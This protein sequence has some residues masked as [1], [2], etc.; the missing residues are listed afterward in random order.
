[1]K[2]PPPILLPPEDFYDTTESELRR[3][4]KFTR[5]LLKQH[6][7]VKPEKMIE[8]QKRESVNE[9]DDVLDEFKTKCTL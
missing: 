3:P 9:E 8:T 6:G 4:L 1:M 7:F 5:R 2:R